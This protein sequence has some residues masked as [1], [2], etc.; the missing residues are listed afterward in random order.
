MT[1]FEKAIADWIE[2]LEDRK[3]SIEKEIS[4]WQDEKKKVEEE[5]IEWKNKNME[6]FIVDKIS[7]CSDGCYELI[8]SYYPCEILHTN[9]YDKLV[10]IGKIY[11]SQEEKEED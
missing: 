6:A 10:E 8:L 9:D 7:K 11:F 3:E 1:K 4:K 2:C 5:L